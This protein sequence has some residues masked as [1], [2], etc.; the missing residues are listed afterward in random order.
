MACGGQ[1]T[2]E[3]GSNDGVVF[4]MRC[5]GQC[6]KGAQVAPLFYL[7]VTKWSVHS[8]RGI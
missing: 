8:P 4:E 1:S 7:H 3:G 5:V 2:T 6:G